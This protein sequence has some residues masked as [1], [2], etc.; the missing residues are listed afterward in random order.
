MID[1]DVFECDFEHINFIFKKNHY[2]SNHMG[3]DI[4]NCFALHEKSLFGSIVGGA[5]YGPPR[6]D[7]YG[8]SVLDLRRFAL[9]EYCPK[10]SESYFL[11][12]TIKILYKKYGH[13][14][15]LTFADE[16]QGHLG[17]IY[18]AC[19]FKKIGETQPSKHIVWNGQQYHMRSLTIDRPYS[20][21]LREAI[22]NGEA[23]IVRGL[24][25]HKFMY[26]T[27]DFG[28]SRK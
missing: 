16:T 15:I 18:K 2:K 10:N 4:T 21:R 26:D 12:R 1:Y 25:K 19:N 28:R 17:T 11:S 22:K 20:L 6:H 7:V 9:E 24:K 27:K 5:V 3:G 8:V 14:R 13:L 23:E